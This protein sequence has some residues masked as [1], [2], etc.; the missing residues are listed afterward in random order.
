MQYGRPAHQ[1]RPDRGLCPN[2]A[3]G[4]A[5]REH[6][7]KL[8][9]ARCGAGGVDGGRACDQGAGGG[10]EGVAAG[11]RAL[12][13]DREQHAGV[14]QP[15]SG[16]S[17]VGR[18]PGKGAARPAAALPGEPAGADPGGVRPAY[19]R[20]QGGGAGTAALADGDHLLHGHPGFGG[21]VYHRGGPAVRQG[22]DR[23]EGQ[24]PHYPAPRQA[25]PEAAEVLQ[26]KETP[27][28]ARCSSPK[29]VPACPA[30]RSGRR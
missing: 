6:H 18:L 20:G 4:G 16:L 9:P 19:R 27:S 17:G 13:R 28:P 29:T 10:V 7:R 23:P 11:G 25:V 2:V 12:P 3:G 21:E 5:P 26:K 8:S 14:R 15:V 22:G 24:D 1:P 30:S